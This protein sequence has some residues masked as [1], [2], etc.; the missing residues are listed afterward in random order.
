MSRRRRL[1]WRRTSREEGAIKKTTKH[2]SFAGYV[3]AQPRV[4]QRA[5]T[6]V[7]AI[8]RK[9]MPGVEERISY[10]IPAFRLN[11][12]NVLYIAG[13]KEHYS[14]YPSTKALERAFAKELAPYELSRKGTIRFPLAEPVP[15]KLIE[16]I[17]KFRANEFADRTT[18]KTTRSATSRS[19]RPR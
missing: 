17:A 5:L 9:A 7:R 3:A 11:G 15:V 6:R 14:L 10:G 12:L 19:A 4:A 8:V 2:D 1:V 18:S 13:W 16:R